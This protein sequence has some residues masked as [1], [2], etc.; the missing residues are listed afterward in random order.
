MSGHP[1]REGAKWPAG[2]E[3]LPKPFGMRELVAR[4]TELIEASQSASPG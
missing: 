1:E 3:L 2:V 4:V